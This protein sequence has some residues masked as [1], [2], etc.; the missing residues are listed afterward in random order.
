[1]TSFRQK[2]VSI[3]TT[4]PRSTVKI[5]LVRINANAFGVVMTII[6]INMSVLHKAKPATSVVG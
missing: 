5:T 3:P 4:E 6:V 2:E 1:M